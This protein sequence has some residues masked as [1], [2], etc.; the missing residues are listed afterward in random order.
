MLQTIESFNA[1]L[2]ISLFVFVGIFLSIIPL[3]SQV[4]LDVKPNH[5]DW[6]YTIGEPIVFN[7][8]VETTDKGIELGNAQ[9][10][11]EIGPEK[12]PPI[13]SGYVGLTNQSA[14]I[15]GGTMHKAGFLRCSVTLIVNNKK[16]SEIATGA[17]EP[18]KIKPTVKCPS[19]FKKFWYKT[20]ADARKIPLD[21]EMTLIEKRC[22]ERYDTYQV[23]Y[24]S[25]NYK[26]RFYGILTI[27]K[28]EGK[29][30]AV[31]RFPGAGVNPLGGNRVIADK[32]VITLD[33][34]IHPFPVL[35]ERKFYDNL[36][37]SPYLDYKFWGVESRESYYYK[38]VIS[39][40]VKAVDV[41]YSLKE[42]DGDNLAAWGS[43]QGGA[44]SIITTSLDKR[45]KML[46]ALC[47]A[48]CDFTGY[49]QGRAGGWPHFFDKNN[50]EKYNS[51]EVI[52]TLSYY[53]VVNFARMITVP[54]YY[55]WGFNDETTPPTS[56]YSAYNVIKVPK[57]I[58]II[59]N[60]RHR[61]YPEQTEKTYGWI[62]GKF[63]E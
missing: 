28:K 56:F 22:T 12:M 62:I 40:C 27:P 11:Y 51:K 34:Y 20:I 4:K 8:S 46:V 39:G 23:S 3:K 37:R 52:K 44:L 2:R 19:D 59:P 57:K 5:E 55:S 15:D 42:F 29:F 21:T 49:L 10:Y 45:I 14:S 17:F 60:G 24:Q 16:Y 47:P 63:G 26:N 31:I 6:V 25:N 36:K 1:N 13:K 38:R 30:P 48:M 50:L 18:E 58:F 7:V 54:G 32:N 9:I 53:D 43:S 33:L 41:I 61:I 35:W